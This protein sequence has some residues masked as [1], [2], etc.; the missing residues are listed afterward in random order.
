M[1]KLFIC[2]T[3]SLALL[4]SLAMAK[5][6]G[7]SVGV[8]LVETKS[9]LSGSGFSFEGSD[10][11]VG[12]D[13]KHAI[14][15][16][17]VA[18]GL[19]IAPAAFFELNNARVTATGTGFNTTADTNNSFGLGFDLGYDINNQV[20]VFANTSWVQARTSGFQENFNDEGISYGFGLKYNVN[21]QVAAVVSYNTVELND[22]YDIDT[23]KLGAAFRF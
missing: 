11:G 5:T 8:N 13:I 2:F 20:A 12:L 22:F 7:N 18:S 9:E 16:E 23:I 21:D 17:N 19:Y 10:I 1:K 4:S 14:S 15:L 6:E 3:A